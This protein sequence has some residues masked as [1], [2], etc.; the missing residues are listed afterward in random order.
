MKLQ[1]H[2]NLRP[3]NTFGIEVHADSFVRLE[4][5]DDLQ[6]AV[7]SGLF[8]K[9]FLILGGG[10]NV[11]FT[12]DYHGTIIQ[13][14]IKGL[15]IKSEDENYVLIS[16]KGG[17]V[18]HDLVLFAV[19]KK[20]G[21]IENLSLIPGTA[22]AAPIQNIGAY[23]VELKD[24]LFSLTAIHLE[25]GEQKVFSN[26][27]C[28]FGYRNSIFKQELKGKYFI[29]EITLRLE[30]NRKVNIQ[31][32]AIE[33][34][35][36]E[37][38]IKNPSVKDVSDAVI[39]IRKSKLPDPAILGNAGSFFKNPEITKDKFDILKK[40]FAD[41]PGYIVS[42]DII[43]VPAGWLIEQCGWKGKRVGN[44]GAHKDQAL[45][46]VNYGGATGNEIYALALEIINSVK[47]KF[48]IEIQ[49]EVNLV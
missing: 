41:L 22:G 5:A 46:L 43:K 18:W 26:A 44:T 19:S 37:N 10:S 38:G 39:Q 33:E 17:E 8:K 40:Q 31:Y 6:E 36:K 3:F 4:T 28:R 20:L 16:A 29:Y 49:P 21:G 27:D 30:K 48:G 9:Q 23:G 42:N 35:L 25:T 13:N 34:V 2:I 7:K 1:Q 11:L 47:N 32:G 24:T 45:V 12:D 15:D 14:A